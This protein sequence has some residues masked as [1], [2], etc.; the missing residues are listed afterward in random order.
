MESQ[1][2]TN[3][4]D[5]ADSETQSSDTWRDRQQTSRNRMRNSPVGGVIE[6]YDTDEEPT[7]SANR[8]QEGKP[9]NICADRTKEDGHVALPHPAR[10]SAQAETEGVKARLAEV[11]ARLA[12][13][14]KRCG[15]YERLVPKLDPNACN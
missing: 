9:R 2:S 15:E 14:S 11:E 6:L 13:V 8:R 3:L 4:I 1:G 10:L 12:D 7:H 5:L